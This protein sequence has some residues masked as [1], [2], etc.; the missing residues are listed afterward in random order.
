MD[1]LFEYF[2]AEEF[3]PKYIHEQKVRARTRTFRLMH[4][5]VRSLVYNFCFQMAF[6]VRTQ[7]SVDPGHPPPPLSYTSSKPIS[8]IFIFLESLG[9]MIMCSQPSLLNFEN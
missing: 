3:S 7:F 8:N 2:V 4:G 9:Q 1:V 6:H 5:F